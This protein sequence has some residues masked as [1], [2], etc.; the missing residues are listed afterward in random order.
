M[1]LVARSVSWPCSSTTPK[2]PYLA[3]TSLQADPM[4]LCR[5][6]GRLRSEPMLSIASSSCWRRTSN[7]CTLATNGHFGP[8]VTIWE[9]SAVICHTEDGR[10]PCRRRPPLPTSLWSASD[11]ALRVEHPEPVR[12]GPVG[13][14]AL[15]ELVADS[16]ELSGLEALLL[17]P[18]IDLGLVLQ[19]GAR[20]RLAEL[21][22]LVER[23]T[24]DGLEPRVVR[25][26]GAL[27][28]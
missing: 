4:I 20:H 1:P 6:A 22:V 8:E 14:H 21:G 5:T 7:R 25:V 10:R 27:G 11:S 13:A 18:L 28:H 24:F 26:V 19:A 16:L 12:Q 9:V 2:A 15:G 3:S 23:D 17:R